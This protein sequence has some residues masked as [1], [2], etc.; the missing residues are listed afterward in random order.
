MGT[1]PRWFAAS[2]VLY[3]AVWA[4]SLGQL[5]ARVPI[6]FGGSG[7]PDEWTSRPAA[8][9]TFGLVG[10]GIALLFAGLAW[11]MGRVGAE[12]I[13]VPHPEYWKRP[14][15]LGTLRRLMTEDM[16]LFGTW[17]LLLLAAVLALVVRAAGL[18]EPRLDEWAV[19][20]VGLYLLV[21]AGHIGWLLT[22]RYAVPEQNT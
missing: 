13:N 19:A 2:G 5:P 14:E 8:L 6:H 12:H 16:W 21:V 9:W 17:T 20:V 18:P 15:H 22:R 10:L 4:W 1:A 7:E 11:L 3:A